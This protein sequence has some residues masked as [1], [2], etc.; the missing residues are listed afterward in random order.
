MKRLISLVLVFITLFM[1]M[2]CTQVSN[3][4]KEKYEKPDDILTP[5]KMAA[6]PIANASMTTEQL[7]QICVDYIK[8]SVSCQWVS[9]GNYFLVEWDNDER[10]FKEGKLYGGIPYV[11]EASGNLYRFMELYDSKTGIV[12]STAMR[13]NPELFATAC[14]GTAGWAWARVINSAEISWT[15]SLNVQHGLVPVGPY[16]YDHEIEQFWKWTKKDKKKHLLKTTAICKENTEQVMYESY[17]MAHLADCFN[18]SGHVAM[19]V[20]EPVVVRNEDGTI[21]AKKSYIMLAEQGQ[22]TV[23]DYHARTTSDGTEYRIRGNDGRKFSFE[24][25]FEKGF[26]VHTFK[27]FLGTDPVEVGEVTV[28]MQENVVSYEE[29]GTGELIANYPISD[30]FTIVRDKDGKV[31]LE[32]VMRTTDHFTKVLTMESC[33]PVRKLRKFRKGDHTIEISVQ[34]SNGERVTAYEGTI[35]Q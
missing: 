34:L 1:L 18:R 25:L 6:I 14:S 2:G 23:A 26:I 16:T 33:M 32:N 8:L 35:T 20:S 10:R 4:R 24:T 31:V 29:I 19:A 15:H 3:A 11:N 21:N 17:A 30:V 12:D 22:Y 28:P 27:E 7:R 13:K 9:D 5:E